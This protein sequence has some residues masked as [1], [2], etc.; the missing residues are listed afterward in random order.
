MG[1]RQKERTRRTKQKIQPYDRVLISCE[2]ERTEPDYLRALCADYRLASA[3]IV[4]TGAS[5]SDPLDVV[6][7][8]LD[9]FYDDGEYDRLYCVFDRDTHDRGRFQQ[10]I[11]A[12]KNERDKNGTHAQCIVSYPCFE[13]WLLIHFERTGKR[14]AAAARSPCKGVISDLR[15]YLP[16]YGKGKARDAY[17]DTKDRIPHA[18]EF[19]QQRRRKK[20][21]TNVDLLVTYLQG[22][23][24]LP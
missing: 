7:Y 11:Q 12:V 22:I 16:K 9:Q 21:R 3:N 5:N 8:G 1:R 10:A 17:H 13:Y 14:Y 20:P 19:A 24:D 4:V 23:R 15:A 2:G 6:E 18:V